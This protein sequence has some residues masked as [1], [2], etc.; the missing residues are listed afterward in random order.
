M[1]FN[2]KN[3]SVAFLNKSHVFQLLHQFQLTSLCKAKTYR[4]LIFTNILIV[5]YADL[6]LLKISCL[7]SRH[8]H[9]HKGFVRTFSF[10]TAENSLFFIGLERYEYLTSLHLATDLPHL[11]DSHLIMPAYSNTLTGGG[12]RVAAQLRGRQLHIPRVCKRAL[13]TVPGTRE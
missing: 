3:L 12:H 5:N 1:E 9:F 7:V 10:E 11:I 6:Y 8:L 13:C 2:F 4:S